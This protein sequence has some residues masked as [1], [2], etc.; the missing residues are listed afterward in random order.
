MGWL[1]LA[2]MIP[3]DLCTKC[4]LLVTSL[5]VSTI[6]CK[7]PDVG[8]AQQPRTNLVDPGSLL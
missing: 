2:I 1:H 6:G 4:M 5:E 7:A 8:I 3:P